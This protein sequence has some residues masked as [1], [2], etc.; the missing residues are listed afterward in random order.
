MVISRSELPLA[1]I[2]ADDPENQARIFFG[3]LSSLWALDIQSEGGQLLVHGDSKVMIVEDVDGS[4]LY[5]VSMATKNL[6]ALVK[7]GSWV[8]LEDLR[9]LLETS[10]RPVTKYRRNEHVEENLWWRAA[11]IDLGTRGQ[12]CYNR[13]P[14]AK[15]IQLSMKPPFPGAAMVYGEEE[16]APPLNLPESYDLTL[17][18]ASKLAGDPSLRNIDQGSQATEINTTQALGDCNQDYTSSIESIQHLIRAQYKESLYISKVSL[19]ITLVVWS[20][21]T[22]ATDVTGILCQRAFITCSCRNQPDRFSKYQHSGT[23]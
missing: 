13:V 17:E 2:D 1:F 4:G 15:R 23:H 20:T 6:Y 11:A 3:R 10:Q 9:G 5:T 18:R 19:S 14:G 21:D 7:L 22:T 16:S 8:T 12:S